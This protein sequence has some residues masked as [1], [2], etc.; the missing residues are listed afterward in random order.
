MMETPVFVGFFVVVL[1]S[2]C[3]FYWWCSKNG[4]I[5]SVP[6]LVDGMVQ[7]DKRRMVEK[8]SELPPATLV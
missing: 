1:G 7:V 5:G 3:F 6:H 8:E 2:I 4:M